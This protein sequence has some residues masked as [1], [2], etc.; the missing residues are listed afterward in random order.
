MPPSAA[1]PPLQCIAGSA[2]GA[3]RMSVCELLCRCEKSSL[4]LAT[5]AFLGANKLLRLHQDGS[6]DCRVGN[7]MFEATGLTQVNRPL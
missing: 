3:E 7:D 5:K 4:R 6:E 1:A 2:A